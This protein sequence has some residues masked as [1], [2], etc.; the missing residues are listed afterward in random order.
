MIY[1]FTY[2]FNVLCDS[3]ANTLC[4]ECDVPSVHNYIYAAL[5]EW[6]GVECYGW[7]IADDENH[8][9]LIHCHS[10]CIYAQQNSITL[11]KQ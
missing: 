6:S 3:V 2:L 1:L 8:S 5:V 7:Y 9:M 11:Q 4:E 10:G